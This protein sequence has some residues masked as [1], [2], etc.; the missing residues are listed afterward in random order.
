MFNKKIVNT[1]RRLIVVG[2]IGNTSHPLLV[3]LSPYLSH[4][5]VVPVVPVDRESCDNFRQFFEKK[6]VIV[7]EVTEGKNILHAYCQAVLSGFL[8]N[9]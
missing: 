1:V 9:I 4:V 6:L 8:L 5:P 3:H 2:L 7:Y